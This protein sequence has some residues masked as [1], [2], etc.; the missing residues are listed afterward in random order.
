MPESDP[1]SGEKWD[2]RS[3]KAAGSGTCGAPKRQEVGHPEQQ[4]D[5]GADPGE[6]PPSWDVPL[7]AG[8]RPLL[9]QE[10]GHAEQQSDRKWDIGAAGPTA[11]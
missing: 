4:S 7:G 9:R 11:A 1:Y 10:V 2:M 6:P 8:I 3:S 5:A